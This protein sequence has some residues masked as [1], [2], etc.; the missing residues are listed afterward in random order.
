MN[1]E[2]KANQSSDDR[3]AVYSHVPRHIL[4]DIKAQSVHAGGYYSAAITHDGLCVVMGGNAHDP[5]A[6]L[7]RLPFPDRH[8]LKISF[9][10][11]HGIVLFKEGKQQIS[12][13]T[14]AQ[15]DAVTEQVNRKLFGRPL[16][17]VF[18]HYTV[19]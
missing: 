13:E 17:G 1:P 11:S 2:V 10:Q 5:D 18:D 7:P 19:Q 3:L 4:P 15:A 12:D 16:R 6:Y 9:G 8:V 14:Q